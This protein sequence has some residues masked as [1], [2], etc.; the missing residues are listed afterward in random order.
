MDTSSRWAAISAAT[1]VRSMDAR[2]RGPAFSSS[3]PGQF[4]Q[5]ET[6]MAIVFGGSWRSTAGPA[7]VPPGHRR[8][9]RGSAEQQ[10][11]V[12]VNTPPPRR[13]GCYVYGH[14]GCYSDFHR[15][16]AVFP[17]APPTLGCF[18]CGQRGCHSSRHEG[19]VGPPAPSAPSQPV[20]PAPGSAT[21]TMNP[22]LNWQRGPQ[23]GD[24]APPFQTPFRPQPD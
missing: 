7:V 11:P 9:S 21:C 10:L 16:D 20:S 1:V 3:G 19:I 6:V 23:H 17:Q 18:V 13:R 8:W 15:E 12:T 24:R 14:S 2:A 22:P 4:W 5:L